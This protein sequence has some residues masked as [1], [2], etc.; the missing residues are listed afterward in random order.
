VTRSA[1]R[2]LLD[3]DVNPETAEIGR[4]LGLDI[5]SVHEI[6]RRGFSDSDQLR[7]ATAEHR[8]MVTRNRNDFIRLTIAWFQTGDLHA[9]VLVV[10]QGLPNNRPDRIAHA[11][12]R[13]LDRTGDPGPHF[14][15]FL[16][17]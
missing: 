15:D 9:G 11:L 14:I 16:A 1:A 2:F 6:D 3:E 7:F 8:I 4:G 12:K 5:L 17:P 13:W 10:P